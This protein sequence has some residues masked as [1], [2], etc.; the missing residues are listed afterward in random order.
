MPSRLSPLIKYWLS[1]GASRL[2][3]LLL[4]RILPIFSV[5]APCHPGAALRNPALAQRGQATG[6][7]ECAIVV[8]VDVTAR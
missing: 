5:V 3:P 2:A 8:V 4:A 1:G 6:S 7:I